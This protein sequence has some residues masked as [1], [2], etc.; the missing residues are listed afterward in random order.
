[1]EEEEFTSRIIQHFSTG[2]LTLPEGATLRSFL[3]DKLNCDPM[4]ITKKFTGACCLGRRVYHLRDRPRVTQAEID[5]A[6]AE[7]DLLE[8]R[9]R[10]RIEHEQAG[11]PLPPRQEMLLAQSHNGVGTLYPMQNRSATNVSQPWLSTFASAGIPT[12]SSLPST[13]PGNRSMQV[14]TPSPYPVARNTPYGA[15]GQWLLPS[16][17]DP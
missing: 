3:A 8:N 16:H 2:V 1:M 9:F 15:S 13:L 12:N 7:L 10:I 14:L 5:M 4:R 11:L 6:K 17:T